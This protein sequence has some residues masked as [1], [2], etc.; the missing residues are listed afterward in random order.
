MRATGYSP[1]AICCMTFWRIFR[2]ASWRFLSSVHGK[3]D[4][5]DGAVLEIP[6]D[7][8]HPLEGDG[9]R[10]KIGMRFEGLHGPDLFPC[11]DE[12]LRCR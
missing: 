1:P 8:D 9:Q 7:V 6:D 3:Q 5:I 12:I 10:L 11:P 2:K 4:G